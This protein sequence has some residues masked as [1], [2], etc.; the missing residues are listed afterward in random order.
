MSLFIVF[1]E[2]GDEVEDVSKDECMESS[3]SEFKCLSGDREDIEGLGRG[4]ESR[5]RCIAKTIK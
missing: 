4:F 3:W 2:K 5:N 1:F